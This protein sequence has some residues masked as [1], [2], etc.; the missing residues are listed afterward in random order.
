M[1]FFVKNRILWSRIFVIFILLLI[2][3]SSYSWSKD[4][5]LYFI[6]QWFGFVC[7]VIATLGRLWCTIYIG[8]YKEDTI[9]TQGPYSIVRNPLYI[10]SFI[11]IIG[12]GSASQNII[13]LLLFIILFTF[14]YPFVVQNEENNLEKA[15]GELFVEY[16]K[17]TPKWIPRFSLYNRPPEYVV[18][19][20]NI[21][22][23]IL[24]SMWFLWFFL[25]L[26]IIEKFQ[27]L[28]WIPVLFTFP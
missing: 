16:R 1:K 8:G 9:I 26:K 21:D 18:H 14:F 27:E 20:K 11:G 19:L 15:H 25:I 3:F 13:A 24:S 12:L 7:V 10:F 6:M 23:A 22:E 17:K 4:S 5:L 2:I 28:T